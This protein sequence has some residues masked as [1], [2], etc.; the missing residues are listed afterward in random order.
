MYLH[1]QH[2]AH[3]DIALDNFVCN[4][5]RDANGRIIRPGY[6]YLVD[7]E[8]SQELPL[9]PGRQSAVELPPSQYPKP[10]G[11]THMDPYSWDIYCVGYFL[12]VVVAVRLGSHLQL[13][14]CLHSL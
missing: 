7:F 2:I 10:G 11:L 4:F 3:L 12:K 1:N 6:P 8:T 13:L 14:L 5:K 9:G